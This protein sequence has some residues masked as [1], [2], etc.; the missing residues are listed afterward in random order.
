[1]TRAVWE[2][3]IVSTYWLS[4]E[5][6]E[7]S[8]PC[9]WV[10]S[11]SSEASEKSQFT[12][13]IYIIFFCISRFNQKCIISY[14]NRYLKAKWRLYYI[15]CQ[16]CSSLKLKSKFPSETSGTEEP[17]GLQTMGLQRVRHDS[18]RTYKWLCILDSETGSL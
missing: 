17:G 14:N 11:L 13:I 15:S 2:T 1:M 7:R 10:S 8:I 18:A 5:S 9:A 3:D 6:S 4:T 16:N 12:F